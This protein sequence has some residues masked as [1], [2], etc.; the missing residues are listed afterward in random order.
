MISSSR[1]NPQRKVA[2]KKL[3]DKDI[4]NGTNVKHEFDEMENHCYESLIQVEETTSVDMRATNNLADEKCELCLESFT[5]GK[6]LK[7]HITT[8]HHDI[9]KINEIQIKDEVDTGF[10]DNDMINETNIE[11]ENDKMEKHCYKSLI[12]IQETKASGM[13]AT[14]SL[15]EEI[16]DL[17]LQSFTSQKQL[18]HHI[19]KSHSGIPMIDECAVTTDVENE[20]NDHRTRNEVNKKTDGCYFESRIETDN[21]KKSA[22]KYNNEDIPKRRF[23]QC[24]L[25][26]KIFDTKKQITLHILKSHQSLT[27]FTRR[28]NDM[29]NETNIEQE[30][31]KMEKHCYKSLIKIQ[32]TKAL[33]ML[34]THSLVEEICD[35]CLQSFT[36]QKQ[37]KHHITK[38]HSGIP[39]IDECAVTT[40]V[41]NEFNDHRTRNEV[42]KKTDGCYFESRIETDN[43]KKSAT[44]YNNEDIPKRRFFQ[45]HLC[46][47]IF[48]T[49]KQ[50]TLHILKS[51]QS[52]TDFTRRDNDMINET[53]I[54]QENDKMEKHCYKSLIK[55]QETKALGMLATHSLVEEICDLCL[56][57]FTSQKQLK[58]H[59][60]K[61]HSGIPMIDECAVTTDVENEFNDHRTRNEVNKK[62]DGCY[63]ES[64]IETDNNKKSATKYN[65][66]DIPKRRFFQCHL[67]QKIFDTK[68][69]ITLHILKS[70]QSLTDFTNTYSN[71]SRAYKCDVCLKPFSTSSNLTIHK[72]VHTGEKPYKCNLCS[73]LF[74]QKSNLTLHKRVHTGEKLFKC[75]LCSKLFT[76][77]FSLTRHKLV[78]SGEKPFKC[79]LCS[80]LFTQKS[81]L[82]L[83]KR[84]HSG[85]K[86]FKCNV[87]SMTFSQLPNLTRHKRVHSG[88]KPFKCNVCSKTFSHTPSLTIHKRVHS[89][90]KPFKCNVCSKTFSD[91]SNLIRHHKRVHTGKKNLKFI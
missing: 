55:I 18:K 80:K 22:T 14:H 21:N 63:F 47:K 3:G 51:H 49:K 89:G 15:V 90:E 76:H 66:E 86:S 2:G 26:Q 32:E 28:D 65:N 25:C 42:N 77:N 31:D 35:L 79:N 7:H 9:F 33:G 8:S 60:T 23:F 1:K 36:S 40:D 67:C 56:Q 50:I 74:T 52:L 34:A 82:A 69:Q 81:N 38:S 71:I 41:E 61:S 57:S 62:T 75:N 64:R 91:K 78:H 73:K 53:N 11:Q 44:K 6:Q 4:I 43:N 30:N 58:H 45:C 46:Q 88:E 59:I 19:T 10:E 13:L 12:K 84:L 29:I 72:R 24:H 20:F 27:D 48:D 70:H 39:M 68:K 83:H 37:L 16:C 87:C 17:C 54:E 85:E 5:S